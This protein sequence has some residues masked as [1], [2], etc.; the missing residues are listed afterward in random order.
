MDG[1]VFVFPGQGAQYQKMGISFYEHY[2]EARAV[3]EEASDV[4]STSLTKLVF[5]SSHEELMLT[6]NSQISIFVVCSAILNVLRKEFPQLS[7]SMCG[8]LSLGEYTALMAS[9]RVSFV[10]ALRLVA[11]RAQHMHDASLE[12]SGKMAAVIG[13]SE[14]EIL[15]CGYSIANINSPNQ[16]VISGMSNVIDNAAI[17]LKNFGAKKV[18]PLEVSGA[19][20]TNFMQ[21]AKEKMVVLIESLDMRDSFI[22]LVMNV[23][24]DFVSDK[25]EIRHNL[26]EQIVSTTRW[27]DC[28]NSIKRRGGRCFY[29]IGPSQLASINRKID[30]D[31]ITIKIEKIEDLDN[32]YANYAR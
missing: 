22:G 7:P 8:G 15:N 18:M 11:A 6:K 28:F 17:V 29:E 31:V 30:K 25:S 13:M 32:V 10:N 19:F 3:F 21:S 14:N 5:K 27:M 24:G 9:G 1:D 20:H 4:L 16:I 26:L 2:P 12:L 23:V